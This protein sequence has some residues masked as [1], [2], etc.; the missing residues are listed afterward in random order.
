MDTPHLDVAKNILQTCSF[1]AKYLDEAR[2]AAQRMEKE[3]KST[4]RDPV[5]VEHGLAMSQAYSLYAIALSIYVPT[6]MRAVQDEAKQK[7]K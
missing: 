1:A 4:G 6:A 5:T 7:E 2:A 3:R